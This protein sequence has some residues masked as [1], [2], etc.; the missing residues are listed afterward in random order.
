[1][2]KM[3]LLMLG[4]IIFAQAV[5]VED[6]SLT[7]AMK[8]RLYQFARRA[9]STRYTVHN[10][11]RIAT[12]CIKNKVPGV[13]IECGVNRGSQVAA[14]GYACQVL[15]D[16]RKIFLFDS[17]KG[18]PLAGPNDNSQP[19]VGKITHNTDVKD[20]DELLVSSNS[21]Y[22]KLGNAG[23]CSVGLV[24]KYM[25]EWGINLNQLV[26][27]KGWFQHVLPKVSHQIGQIALLRLDGDLYESTKVCLEYLYP[28]VVKGGYVV[29][30][31]Y[32]LG[33]CHKAV[34]EYL[35]A[36]GLNPE[37]IK[38]VKGGGPVYWQVT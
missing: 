1:M 2:K 24:K 16:K 18:I 38:V 12:A 20:L 9:S 25:R 22:S 35:Y 3:Y 19:G 28:K 14:M 33:G 36:H 23:M 13:F 7:G 26:F 10:S 29:I 5:Q 6:V 15:N 21:V 27:Y 17:F 11:Y 37:I 32:A 34:Q 30:D 31:D 8:K 4:T